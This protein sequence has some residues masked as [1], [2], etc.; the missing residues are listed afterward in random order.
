MTL[1]SF[2][3]FEDLSFWGQC[4]FNHS[5]VNSADSSSNF[6]RISTVIQAPDFIWV[7]NAAFPQ[8]AYTFSSLCIS[9][10]NQKD[11]T[12]RQRSLEG[13]RAGRQVSF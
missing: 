1:V 10:C 4:G 9:R 11:G 3:S 5:L 7:V 13:G 6:P 2:A 8:W 12:T